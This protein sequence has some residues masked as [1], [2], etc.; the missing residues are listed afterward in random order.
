MPTYEERLVWSA[1]DGHG[2]RTHPLGGFCVG[3]L[4]CW[5]D[6]MPLPR[7]ALYAQGEDLHVAVWPGGIHNTRDITWYIALESRSY[8]ASVSG[9][10]A[11]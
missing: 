6:W 7:A 5:E 9:F 2:L 8:V 1:G 3:P 10:D 11:P 4:N